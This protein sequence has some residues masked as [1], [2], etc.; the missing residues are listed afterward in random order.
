MYFETW[1]NLE[2]FGS[3]NYFVEKKLHVHVVNLDIFLFVLTGDVLSNVIP[4]M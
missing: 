4:A 2:L 3:N 1:E